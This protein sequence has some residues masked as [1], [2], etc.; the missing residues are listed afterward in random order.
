VPD[1]HAAHAT[2]TARGIQF[3]HVPHMIHRHEDGTEEWMAFFT[4]NE[5]RPL[6]IMSQAKP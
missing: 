1:I 6:G 2:L 4:D 3:T 5:A